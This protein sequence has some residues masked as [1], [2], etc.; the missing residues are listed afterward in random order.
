MVTEHTM[1]AFDADLQDLARIVA[2]MGGLA[3][4]QISDAIDALDRRDSMLAQQV[5]ASD[6]QIDALQREIEEKVILT[7]ARRQP[8]AVD[9]REV[10]GAL[11][12][13]NDLERIGDLAKNIAKRVLVLDSEFR[14]AKGD[15]RGRAHGRTGARADQGRI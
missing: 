8:M 3:E 2:E 14:L 6:G 9:L 13:S 11:R 1:K 10:V 12:I 7:I 5:I 15:A 4:Q